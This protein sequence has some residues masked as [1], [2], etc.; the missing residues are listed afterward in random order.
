MLLCNNISHYEMQFRNLENNLGA[1]K[2][3]R[4]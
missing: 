2:I 3:R 1:V 4:L